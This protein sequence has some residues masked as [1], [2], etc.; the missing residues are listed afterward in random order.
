[1]HT[2]E[3]LVIIVS[4][5]TNLTASVNGVHDVGRYNG[6]YSALRHASHRFQLF[7]LARLKFPRQ[8]QARFFSRV[9]LEASASNTV[10]FAFLWK[11][12]SG[13]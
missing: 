6:P 3:T 7:P 12:H 11:W 8:P 5:S 1:M 13:L 4:I 10:T 9:P 2:E